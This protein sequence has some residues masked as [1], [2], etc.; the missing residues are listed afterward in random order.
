MMRLASHPITPPT[1]KVMMMPMC[2]SLRK[3]VVWPRSQRPHPSSVRP[4]GGLP[5]NRGEDRDGSRTA[6]ARTRGRCRAAVA[7][8]ADGRARLQ[9]RVGH[10]RFR[11][12]SAVTLATHD[13]RR[14]V[15]FYRAL[16]LELAS[17]GE[18]AGF[19]SFVV[20]DGHL[21]LIAAPPEARWGWW[22]RIVHVD[23]V[24]ALHARALAA[25]LARKRRRGTPSR[26]SATSTSRI[27]TVTSCPSRA[28]SERPAGVERI[29]ARAV[30]RCPT[31]TGPR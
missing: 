12:I 19:T 11:A 29:P 1:I 26:A 8:L 18:T 10:P 14:A 31:G 9:C 13:M 30:G 6:G 28:R 7:R 4:C 5:V 3:P 20:G 17:G 24:D 21:N 23:D 15:R 22:G 25:G 16:G 27:P 2:P